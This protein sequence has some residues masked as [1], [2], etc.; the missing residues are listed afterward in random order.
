MSGFNSL[1]LHH[2]FSKIVD[3]QSL[4]THWSVL[5][6]KAGGMAIEEI[7]DEEE[8]DVFYVTIVMMIIGI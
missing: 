3:D 4:Q 6:A 1:H 2:C 5:R 8:G 7:R